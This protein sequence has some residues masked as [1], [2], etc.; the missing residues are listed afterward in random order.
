MKHILGI[1]SVEAK[2]DIAQCPPDGKYDLRGH[3]QG[4]QNGLGCGDEYPTA[5]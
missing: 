2:L 4:F 1:N 5:C 3:G